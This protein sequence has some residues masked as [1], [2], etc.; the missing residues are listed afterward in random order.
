MLNPM[1]SCCPFCVFVPKPRG[2]NLS[3]RRDFRRVAP[4]PTGIPTRDSPT[5]LQRT[6]QGDAFS[7]H[8]RRVLA[9]PK[10]SPQADGKT[11]PGGEDFLMTQLQLHRPLPPFAPNRRYRFERVP[12]V[13][14]NHAAIVRGRTGRVENLGAG[15]ETG[16]VIN[17]LSKGRPRKSAVRP[18][19]TES[20]QSSACRSCN[21]S[22]VRVV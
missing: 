12:G 9:S 7:P 10:L 11:W 20:Y 6:P 5:L 17:R 3:M 14:S 19:G 2:S 1:L 16:T 13:Q 18:A 21:R 22:V 15:H 8:R 4:L